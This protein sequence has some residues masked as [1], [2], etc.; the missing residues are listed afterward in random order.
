[1]NENAKQLSQQNQVI[2]E[3]VKGI[4]NMMELLKKSVE[5]NEQADKI[6]KVQNQI[7]Q[8]TVVINEDIAERIH[9]EN[10][11]FSN[12]ASM[13]QSNTEEIMV[14]SNQVDSLNDMIKELEE[15]MGV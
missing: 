3:T 8:E 13:V 5:A 7:I 6:R 14:L 1:M 2:V 4:R 10:D 12:I 11:E 9:Q 15:M